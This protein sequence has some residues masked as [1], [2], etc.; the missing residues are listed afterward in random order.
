MW[1]PGY[2][3]STEKELCEELDVS[4]IAVRQ[5]IERLSTLNVLIKQ[6]G[7]GTYVAEYQKLMFMPMPFY[8]INKDKA[9][10]IL[11]FRKMFDSNNAQLF[12][13]K[14]KDKD[15]YLLEENFKNMKAV[16]NNP[17][18]FRYYDN[19]FHTLIAKGTKNDIIIQI[20][21]LFNDMLVGLQMTIYSKADPASAIEQH[22]Q[23]I[24][25]IR[26]K[27]ADLASIYTKMHIEKSIEALK[28][29]D[30]S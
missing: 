28:K 19:E 2:K 15:L 13:E 23:I 3:I 7:S 14:S 4:R 11:E 9:L 29:M 18:K 12:V 17:K 16:I 24:E 25:S 21:H 20:S 8:H 5:A 27:N 1:K 26:M 6:Q 10:T 22:E 30:I